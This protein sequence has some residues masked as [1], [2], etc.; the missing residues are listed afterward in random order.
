MGNILPTFEHIK[1]HQDKKKKNEEL[2]LPSK[3]NVD[4]DLLAVEFW[5][6]NAN[7]TRKA[8]RLPVNAIQLHTN[9][10][11]VNSNYFSKLKYSATEGP[12]LQYIAKKGC[13]QIQR[14]SQ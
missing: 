8:L 6:S 11:T 1:G 7:S 10:V 3:L 13:G 9:G 4:A 2:S 5:A 14:W 12:L